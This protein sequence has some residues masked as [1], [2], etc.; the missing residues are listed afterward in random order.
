VLALNSCLLP[1]AALH[2]AAVLTS[3]G[4][5]S[6]RSGFHE[7]HKRLAGFHATQCGFC[8]PG[9]AVA[10]HAALA[11]AADQQQQQCTLQAAG[12]GSAGGTCNQEQHGNSLS[13]TACNGQGTCASNSMNG[14]MEKHSSG[15]SSS[16]CVLPAAE[17]LSALDGNL[18]RCTGWRPIADAAKSCCSDV[19]IED[20]GLCSINKEQLGPLTSPQQLQPA[21]LQQPLPVV[22]QLQPNEQQQQQFEA[23]LK[24]IRPG[25]VL[26]PVTLQQL[27]A[28]VAAA[29][30]S[31]V[32]VHLIAGN[33][34]AGIYKQQWRAAA[35]AAC[36]VVRH[37][38]ELQQL[39]VQQASEAG[40]RASRLL[41]G[42]GVTISQML[43]CLQDL[44]AA[45]EAAGRQ[46]G[47]RNLRFLCSHLARIAGR[48]VRNA[49]TL[50]GHLALV[51][52]QQ[53]ES[54]LMPM[55]LA[56]GGGRVW[57]TAVPA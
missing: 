41:A 50:G 32:P 43:R 24:G 40:S 54:D 34:G 13:H 39:T 52:Q 18:C 19:D 46:L 27:L 20:L 23:A 1:V 51:R 30:T 45:E 6:S 55:M 16:G 31:G 9:M 42:A 57:R 28:A 15:S 56:A 53:L 44:A 47:A 26:L 25:C 22:A 49:A 36:I 12:T 8:T 48:L 29:G 5:G 2:G 7:L 38:P 4:L 35:G 14:C 17:L 11:A 3:S 10:L 21:V 33:T 37:V